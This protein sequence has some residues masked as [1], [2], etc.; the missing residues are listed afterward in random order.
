MKMDNKQTVFTLGCVLA[1]H[2]ILETI[3]DP[4]K[5]ESLLVVKKDEGFTVEDHF[6]DPINE[7]TYRPMKDENIRSGI[8][9]LPNEIGQSCS[10]DQM[11]DLIRS[12]INRF[13]DLDEDGLWIASAY[14]MMTH[15]YDIFEK[16]PYLRFFGCY[17]SGKSRALKTL[18]G[19][20][21][22]P[23]NLGASQTAP[24]LFR[25]LDLYGH[26]TL[27]LDE[28]NFADSTR[29][30]DMVKILNDGYS[31]DGVVSRCDP[32]TYQPRTFQVFSPKVLA[33]HTVFDDPA[34]ES[35]MFSLLMKPTLRKD[36]QISMP[37]LLYDE[38]IKLIRNNLLRFRLDN[39]W[40]VDTQQR[41]AELGQFEA[42]AQEIAFPLIAVQFPRKVSTHLINFLERSQE[43]QCQR[44][45]FDDDAI[46]AKVALRCLED[47]RGNLSLKEFVQMVSDTEN[48]ELP[49]K[50]A[51]HLLKQFGAGMSRAN[52][53]MVINLK[54]IPVG[55]LK[56]RYGN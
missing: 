47:N 55:F 8:I 22:H 40:N 23:I 27:L 14:V 48:A 32:K 7:I 33:N 24:N 17:G 20:C 36:I 5:D 50:R 28:V 6:Q 29:S 56:N 30:S 15:L 4:R 10:A 25:M 19:V 46:V 13:V 49:N 51:A 53:G 35:R 34:L 2:T 26:G 54:T 1:D 52:Q 9:T 45:M 11:M 21:Y 31:R 41:F 16:V 12:Y 18:K 38:E 42:R 43:E 39:Y 3:Y 37:N 44:Y